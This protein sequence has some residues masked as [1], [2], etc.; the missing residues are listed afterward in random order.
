MQKKKKKNR[1][2]TIL[3]VSNLKI[4]FLLI[5]RLYEIKFEKSFN[6]NDFYMRDKKKTINV[7]SF[8]F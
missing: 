7:E 1:L 3:Y 2:I 6:E 5:K 4:N 8:R